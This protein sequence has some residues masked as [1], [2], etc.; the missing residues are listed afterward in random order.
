MIVKILE[1]IQLFSALR[2]WKLHQFAPKFS[3]NVSTKGGNIITNFFLKMEDDLNNPK[4]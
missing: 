1:F 3:Q 4:Q 2:A